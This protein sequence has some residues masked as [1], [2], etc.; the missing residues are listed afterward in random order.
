MACVFFFVSL[1]GNEDNNTISDKYEIII[2][3]N[4]CVSRNVMSC[5]FSFS[6]LGNNEDNNNTKSDI[7]IT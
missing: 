1:L 3:I 6:L 7:E 5:V 2:I 4:V